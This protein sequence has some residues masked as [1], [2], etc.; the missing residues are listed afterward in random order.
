MPSYQS[1][2][3]QPNLKSI[4]LEKMGDHSRVR[5]ILILASILKK[6]P[7]FKDLAEFLDGKKTEVRLLEDAYIASRYLMR[8][9]TKEEAETIINVAEEVL[10]HGGLC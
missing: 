5:S 10:K 6:L 7:N 9:Y 1:R 3:F 4:L 8:E 2:P